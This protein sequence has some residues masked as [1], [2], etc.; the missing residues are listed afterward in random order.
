MV[1]T[2][3]F[4]FSI[5]AVAIIRVE[6]A[7]TTAAMAAKFLFA[8]FSFS[9]TGQFTACAA[10]AYMGLSYH[11]P[12]F[13]HNSHDSTTTEIYNRMKA[14]GSSGADIFKSIMTFNKTLPE[15]YQK[16]TRIN[17]IANAA[18]P[19]STAS[20]TVDFTSMT[21]NEFSQ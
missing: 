17:I 11:A 6:C 14:N 5:F 21:P 4:V 8:C 2:Q 12:Y 3:D 7:V 16:A 20:S 1:R 13:T 19:D 15:D 18:I 9:V 10:R